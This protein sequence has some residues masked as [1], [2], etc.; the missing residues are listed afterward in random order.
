[1]T[2]GHYPRDLAG[3]GRQLPDPQ[4]PGGASIAVTF[5]VNYEAGGE[6]SV[7][8]GDDTS[9]G[10]LNDI[11][12]PA[13]TGARSML[14]ES[15]FEYGSRRGIWRLLDAFES[16]G[17]QA[18]ILAVV[19][20]LK[21]N[22]EFVAAI[23]EG[24]HELVSHGWRWIDY[25][26][27]DAATERQHI[28]DAVAEITRLTGSAP[29][30]WMTGRPSPDTRRLLIEHGGFLYDRDSLND[31]L[32]YWLHEHGHDHLVIPYSY[33]TNDNRFNENSGFSTADDCFQYMR[34]AFDVLRAEGRAGQPRMMSIGLH[35]RLI[36]RPGRIG[37]L[38]RFL[39]HIQS[40]D[41]V[42][43]CTGQQIAEHWRATH[44]PA[45]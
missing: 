9:E 16:R 7:L 24:G 35:D 13:V 1:M 3:Y 6:L 17:L 14:A 23:A 11:G 32:P 45:G 18:S 28:A 12:F 22:P 38:T 34:D 33:E 40:F 4:W 21:H 43:I 36:G 25:Q 10:M 44:P 20:G 8:H 30:G 29:V 2:E 19:S 5:A 27:V 15:A 42:W 37:G 41:D 26:H 31:E 39:D